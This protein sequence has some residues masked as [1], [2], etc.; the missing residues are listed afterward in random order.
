MCIRCARPEEAAVLTELSFAA[1]R[2]WGYPEAYLDQWRQELT[3]SG[4]YIAEYTV[5]LYESGS[6]FGYYSVVDLVEETTVGSIVLPA[7]TWLEHMFVRP[8][9][10]GNGIGTTLFRHMVAV[11]RNQGVSRLSILAD[12]HARGFYEKMGCRYVREYPSSIPLR[13]TPLLELK[14]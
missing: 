4:T 8:S 12:P 2:Y 3:I 9:A 5:Y 6:I 11:C 7:G 1:K 10:I 13:T 14:P